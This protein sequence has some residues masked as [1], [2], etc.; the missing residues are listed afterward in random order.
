MRKKSKIVEW[1]DTN[2]KPY[3]LSYAFSLPISNRCCFF[4]ANTCKGWRKILNLANALAH[5]NR[6]SFVFL[7]GT[8]KSETLN[9]YLKNLGNEQL[10]GL[11]ADYISTDDIKKIDD[12]E[13]WLVGLQK[14]GG[15]AKDENNEWVFDVSENFKKWLI[16]GEAKQKYENFLIAKQTIDVISQAVFNKGFSVVGNVNQKHVSTKIDEIEEDLLSVIKELYPLGIEADT[17]NLFAYKRVAVPKMIKLGLNTETDDSLVVNCGIRLKKESGLAQL[18]LFDDYSPNATR[19][20]ELIRETYKRDLQELGYS[21]ALTLRSALVN[22]PYGLYECNY[23]YYVLAYAL[24][25]F[26]QGYFYVHTN[27]AN[28]CTP[29]EQVELNKLNLFLP[30]ICRQSEKQKSLIKKLRELFDITKETATVG[31]ALIWARDWITNNIHFDTI[32]RISHTLFT[33]VKEDMKVYSLETEEYDDWLDDKVFGELYAKLR[34]ADDDFF[35]RLTEKYGEEKA[36]L[37]K[38][39]GYVKGGAG[40]WLWP[41]E[42]VNEI[43]EDYMSQ[44][45]CRECGRT[46]SHSHISNE[47]CY[48]VVNY[49]RDRETHDFTLK[50]IIGLNKKFFGRYQKE[51]YC[52]PCMATILETSEWELWEKMHEFKES[53]CTLFQ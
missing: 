3:Y 18:T 17:S 28:S 36:R 26:Q 21:N 14:S 42:W 12:S 53:G 19:I 41:K 24:S 4:W 22:R 45:L 2:N 23:Y 25:I 15:R 13:A 16:S 50:E 27:I 46:I 1:K 7:Y 35:V 48:E 51:C 8:I 40:G 39:H 34:T 33:L 38:R 47:H 52:I 30:I 11:R 9:N 31:E 43:V 32:D 20:I 49:E 37:Y 10:I 5:G 44:V 6:M 29:I